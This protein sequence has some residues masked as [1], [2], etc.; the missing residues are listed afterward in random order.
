M[1]EANTRTSISVDRAR[2]SRAPG[3]RVLREIFVL[4]D[5]EFP[6]TVGQDVSPRNIL[7]QILVI[8][9]PGVSPGGLERADIYRG[10]VRDMRADFHLT[11]I[12]CRAHETECLQEGNSG[13]KL[14]R[15]MAIIRAE[16]RAFSRRAPM[17]RNAADRRKK[18]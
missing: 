12:T 14:M 1:R 7:K 3:E 16:L 9:R 2:R 10:R 11:V 4:E 17:K 18:I 13:C 5:G 6:A 15:V 8:R